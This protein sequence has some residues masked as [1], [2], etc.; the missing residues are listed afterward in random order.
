M[1]I[2][3]ALNYR[4]IDIPK[5]R[6]ERDLRNLYVQ[7]AAYHADENGFDQFKTALDRQID[8]DAGVHIMTWDEMREGS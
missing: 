7:R 3:R 8:P 4:N 6:A 1:T 2:R 5:L